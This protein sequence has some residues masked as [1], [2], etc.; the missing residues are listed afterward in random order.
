MPSIKARVRSRCPS[1]KAPSRIPTTGPRL[2][3]HP[4]CPE[5]M[6]GRCDQIEPPS[7]AV[8]DGHDA[9][10]LLYGGPAG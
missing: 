6:P 8:G 1:S 4:R 7:L 5:F 10:C 9:A 3:F 2:P